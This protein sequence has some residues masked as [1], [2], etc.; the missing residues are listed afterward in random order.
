[1]VG[2]VY[3]LTVRVYSEISIFSW[4]SIRPAMFCSGAFARCIIVWC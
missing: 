2:F 3:C 1:M 4:S